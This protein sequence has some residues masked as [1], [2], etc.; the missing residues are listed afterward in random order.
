MA[1]T[2][3]G[4]DADLARAVR[5]WHDALRTFDMAAALT[6]CQ[7]IDVLLDRRLACAGS[8]VKP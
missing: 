1:E 7:R 3:T 2:L 5:Q 6:V 8:S 4:V